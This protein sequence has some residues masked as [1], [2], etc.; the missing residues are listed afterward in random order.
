MWDELGKHQFDY[1]IKHALQKETKPL[2]YRR[3]SELLTELE[4]TGLVVS[5]TSS[6]GR[7]GYGTQYKLVVS[8][9]MIGMTTFPEFWKSIVKRKS[10]Q[11]YS[12]KLSNLGSSN[13]SP[14]LKNL[15]STLDDLTQSEWNEYVGID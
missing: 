3:V 6:K 15:R 10:E 5:Q 9:E 7:H 12:L 14:Y 8:P 1:L 4:N 2:G 11:E 13:R